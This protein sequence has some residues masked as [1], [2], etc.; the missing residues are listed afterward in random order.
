MFLF[1]GTSGVG[2]TELARALA[3]YLF[4]EGGA[5][6]KLDM[7]EYGERFTGSRLLGAPPGY[8]GHGDEGQ[9]TGPL[10]NRP[11]AVVLLDEFEKAHSD[12]AATFL[13]L[14]DEGVMTDSEGRTIHARE[15]YF[16]LTTNIGGQRSDHTRVGFG[17]DHIQARKAA[18]REAVKDRFRPELLNRMDDIVV[19][20][21]LQ[22]KTLTAIA[23]LQLEKLAARAAKMGVTLSWG[24]RLTQ[25]LVTWRAEREWG[26]RPVLR[27]VDALVSEPLG[28]LLLERCGDEPTA[29]RARLDDNRV[30]LEEQTPARGQNS[31]PPD[32]KVKPS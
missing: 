7:S 19:F 26:A 10:R 23:E 22:T 24:P 21:P 5:L 11:Y 20:D 6:I 4:P 18:V 30:V 16:I 2:K 9:L 13:S 25:F 1:A 17:G 32:T 3:D 12:V 14:F 28:V 29:V 8:A 15:A 27:A 31:P